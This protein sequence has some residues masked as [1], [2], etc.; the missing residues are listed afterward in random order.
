MDEE[1]VGYHGT[2]RTL[3]ELIC[4]NNFN[5]N[6]DKENKLFLGSGI[7]FFYSCDDAID[8]NVKKFR[9]EYS[10]LPNWENLIDN[11]AVIESVIKANKDDMLDLDEKD[12]LFKLEILIEKINKKLITN[13]EYIRAKNKTAAIIN[14][15]YQR[16][17]IDKKI[18]SKTFMEKIDTRNLSGLKNYPR[19]MFCVKDNSIIVENKEK[20]DIDKEIFDSIIYF[21]RYR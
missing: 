9:K 12:K 6:E 19:K 2:K 3:V 1:I 5:I 18:V 20:I 15:M 16:K 4:S 11:Y 17:L 21:Y 8:W 13:Q 14:M 7:Y 10:H